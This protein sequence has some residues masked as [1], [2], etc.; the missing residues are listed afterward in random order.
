VEVEEHLLHEQEPLVALE[1]LLF[2]TK[3]AQEALAELLLLLAVTPITHLLH[4]AHL[5]PNQFF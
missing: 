1:S 4:L 2:A 5:L 3:A